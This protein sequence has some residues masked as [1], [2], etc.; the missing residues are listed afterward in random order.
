MN[1]NTRYSGFAIGTIL[2]AVVLIAAIVS[3]IAVASR[4]SVASGDAEQARI[5]ATTLVNAAIQFDQAFDRAT[6]SGMDI[7]QLT[8][9]TPV[10]YNVTFDPDSTDCW[11]NQFSNNTCN[12]T[13]NCFFGTNGFMDRP[14]TIPAAVYCNIPPDPPNLTPQF[15]L[16]TNVNIAGIGNG[17]TAIM[18]SGINDRMCRHINSLVMNR[19]VNQAP[20]ES[21]TNLFLPWLGD[22]AENIEINIG[23]G[24]LGAIETG[25]MDGVA[26]GCFLLGNFGYRVY[27]RIMN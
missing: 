25:V 7:R 6:A 26:E 15:Q 14:P 18:I 19:P 11:A 17:L 5:N 1:P 9:G 4:G 2:L 20:P 27:Y 23:T 16:R 3:A 13:P 12:N 21:S 10:F 8:F 24:A 22:A